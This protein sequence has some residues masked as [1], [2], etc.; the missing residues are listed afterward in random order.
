MKYSIIL[1]LVLL[2]IVSCDK[3]EEPEEFFKDENKTVQDANEPAVQNDM[4]SDVKVD[5][6]YFSDECKKFR[7]L[8]IQR[9]YDAMIGKFKFDSLKTMTY[10][11]CLT[12]EMLKK[13]ACEE[14]IELKE[15]MKKM[16]PEEQREIMAPIV[17]TCSE[18]LKEWEKNRQAK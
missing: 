9:F 17:K 6:V 11:E 18:R 4:T 3:N 8:N 12:D 15:K 16:T 1:F 5:T 7:R 2:I 14:I 13:Y 10:C